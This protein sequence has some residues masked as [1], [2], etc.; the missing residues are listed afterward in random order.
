MWILWFL[1]P[2]VFLGDFSTDLTIG[3]RSLQQIRTLIPERL[4]EEKFSISV[5]QKGF[6]QALDASPV[7]SL[8]DPY[9]PPM[10]AFGLSRFYYSHWTLSG[11]PIRILDG[12][13]EFELGPYWIYPTA[14]HQL[15]L[16]HSQAP[17]L[18]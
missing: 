10:R 15:F 12:Y 17:R 11:E 5:D 7:N 18:Q 3:L 2:S 1:V 9:L 6:M 16:Y 4:S 8:N 13:L 14:L